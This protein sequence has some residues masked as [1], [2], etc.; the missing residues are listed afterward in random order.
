[1]SV[2]DKCKHVFERVARNLFDA[3][4]LFTDHVV[5]MW[6]EWLCEFGEWCPATYGSSSD[7][8]FG[9]KLKC[10]IDARSVNLWCALG[11]LAI[12]ERFVCVRER[13]KHS[14]AGL[15]D[16]LPRLFQDGF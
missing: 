2:S 7:A 13:L 10:A 3:S 9:K 12:F 15:S 1:M 4:T 5:M 14:L 6:L 8:E 11:N 16:T